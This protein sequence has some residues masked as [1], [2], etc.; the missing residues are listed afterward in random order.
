MLAED[1]GDRRRRAVAI[2]VVEARSVIGEVDRIDGVRGRD[3]DIGARGNRKIFGRRAI[4][5]PRAGM[6]HGGDADQPRGPGVGCELDPWR[7]AVAAIAGIG[8]NER[9]D[10]RGAEPA[11]RIG[12]VEAAGLV[13]A[14]KMR[15]HGSAAPPYERGLSA[16]THR[17]V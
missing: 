6:K 1:L 16:A 7:P 5:R 10:R 13:V 2:D 17:K 8:T 9:L 11:R 15:I 3:G 12:E 14:G 4:R